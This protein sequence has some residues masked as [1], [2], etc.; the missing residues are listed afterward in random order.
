MNIC[1]VPDGDHSYLIDCDACG[2]LG[3]VERT[4]LHHAVGLHLLD[5]GIEPPLTNHC[6]CGYDYARVTGHRLDH[7]TCNNCDWECYGMFAIALAAIVGTLLGIFVVTI[8]SG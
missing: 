8:I 6:D 1:A 2:P 5:H 3:V 4:S 7:A